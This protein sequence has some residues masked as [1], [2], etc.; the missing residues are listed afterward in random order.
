MNDLNLC[1]K[2]LEKK[3]QIKPKVNRRKEG[4]NK[5]KKINEI[6]NS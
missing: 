5:N 6:E 4:N 2:K 1:T 3:E